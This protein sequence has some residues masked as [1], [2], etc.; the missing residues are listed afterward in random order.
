MFLDEY[1]LLKRTINRV[2]IAVL[3]DLIITALLFLA[4]LLA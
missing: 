1:E 4:V 2:F 3:F